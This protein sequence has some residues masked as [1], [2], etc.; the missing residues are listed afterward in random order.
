MTNT[1]TVL[2]LNTT[3]PLVLN[4]RKKKSFPYN[5]FCMV[6]AFVKPNLFNY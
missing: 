6:F 1:A 4:E 5:I 2:R 3:N